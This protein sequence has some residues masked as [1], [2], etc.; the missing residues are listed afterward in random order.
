M[1]YL[2]V[3]MSV[4][5]DLGEHLVHKGFAV[6]KPNGLVPRENELLLVE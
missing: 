5:G 4:E 2:E 3:L 1:G 6:K